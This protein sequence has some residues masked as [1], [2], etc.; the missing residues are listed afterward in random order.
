MFANF[1]FG[2]FMPIFAEKFSV[3]KRVIGGIII[4]LFF[5]ILLV[6]V[7]VVYNTDAGFGLS[8]VITFCVGNLL[9]YNFKGSMNSISQNTLIAVASQ[10]GGSL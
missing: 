5:L 10:T 1:I 6:I 2:P 3:K 4:L 8:L 9:I 7:A